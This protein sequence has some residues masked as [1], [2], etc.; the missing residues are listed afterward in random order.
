VLILPPGHGQVVATRRR[1]TRRERWIVGGVAALA[2]ALAVIVVIAFAAGNPKLGRGCIDVTGPSS[3][4]AQGV[5]AC[6]ADAR[7]IC[8]TANTRSGY[9]GGLATLIVH[10]CRQQGIPVG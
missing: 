10:Q 9:R 4:G 2:A 6:G 1:L 3:M 7:A 5:S 8:T